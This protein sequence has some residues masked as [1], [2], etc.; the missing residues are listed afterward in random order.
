MVGPIDKELLGEEAAIEKLE[1][2]TF[3]QTG[4]IKELE[5]KIEVLQREAEEEDQ[6]GIFNVKAERVETKSNEAQGMELE[7]QMCEAERARARQSRGENT[8]KAGLTEAEERERMYAIE[9][10]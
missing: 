8:L 2:M 9:G 3:E 10:E 1:R 5:A 4:I 7:V 6:M